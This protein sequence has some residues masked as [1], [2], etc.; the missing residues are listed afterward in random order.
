[1]F[2]PLHC[3]AGADCMME[4]KRCEQRSWPLILALVGLP[5]PNQFELSQKGQFCYL[6]WSDNEP[7]R[8]LLNWWNVCQ[9]EDTCGAS[10]SLN[11]CGGQLAGWSAWKLKYLQILTDFKWNL[12]VRT[13]NGRIVTDLKFYQL[14]G[15]HISGERRLL[16]FV[17]V[18]RGKNVI[19]A[20]LFH[21]CVTDVVSLNVFC[22]FEVPLRV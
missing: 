14:Q 13:Q 9:H 12:K 17:S 2:R 16:S 19:W 22:G 20:L 15:H 4:R 3:Q 7:V 5:V 8:F 18:N 21:R 11:I 1:M 6:N 10:L